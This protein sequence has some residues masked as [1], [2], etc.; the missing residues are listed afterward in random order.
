MTQPQQFIPCS[1][2]ED[3][4]WSFACANIRA[5]SG[6][7]LASFNA[8]TNPQNVS[9]VFLALLYCCIFIYTVPWLPSVFLPP[10]PKL[11]VLLVFHWIP[12]CIIEFTDISSNHL[13]YDW[14]AAFFWNSCQACLQ[15]KMRL[16][17]MQFTVFGCWCGAVVLF[18][19]LIL[20]LCVYSSVSAATCGLT[21]YGFFTLPKYIT[22]QPS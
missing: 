13:T 6:T 21:I 7:S 10:T 14:Y 17:M 15:N 8:S 12:I 4:F 3:S 5:T 19:P 20:C 9:F 1:S 18:H 2:Y 16:E 22:N 11:P